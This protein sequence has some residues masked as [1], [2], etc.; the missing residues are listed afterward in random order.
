MMKGV[1]LSIDPQAQI[2][3]LTHDI[4]P[5]DIGRAARVLQ[6]AWPYF[7]EKTVHVVVVDPGVGSL[8]RII[9]AEA[10]GHFF[11]GPDNGVLWPTLR[12]GTEATLVRVE[13]PAYRLPNI[14]R[15]FH[16]RDI[17]APAAA[18]L[19]QG[20]AIRQLGP[21]VPLEKLLQFEPVAPRAL[22]DGSLAGRVVAVDRFG[23]LITNISAGDLDSAFPNIPKQD[24][25]VRINDKEIDGISECYAD[26]P[27]N[28]A[29]ALVGSADE[30]ELSVNCGSAEIYFKG[31]KGNAVTVHR[32][33]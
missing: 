8:R 14:S 27:A 2:V 19:S 12:N 18:H 10:W 11:I 25:A 22:A 26:V 24:L 29:L 33:S 16:G 1:I 4:N 28:N 31:C 9:A 6:T 3:D 23:N 30:L 32:K 17:F 15:T 13:N 5:Q 21:Q 20:V 7:P